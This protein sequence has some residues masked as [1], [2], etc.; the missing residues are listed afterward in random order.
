VLGRVNE[1][2][3]VPELQLLERF[4]RFM[5]AVMTEA[6]DREFCFAAGS[7]M[8]D[9]LCGRVTGHDAVVMQRREGKPTYFACGTCLM[10]RSISSSQSPER[11]PA[12]GRNRPGSFLSFKGEPADSLRRYGLMLPQRSDGRRRWLGC[13]LDARIHGI[14]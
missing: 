10:L 13:R 8:A 1:D 11:T 12:S 3:V 9:G 5:V 4:H 7:C 2:H 6:M 14:A